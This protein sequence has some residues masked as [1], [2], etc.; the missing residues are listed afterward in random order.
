M[1]TVMCSDVWSTVRTERCSVQH[2]TVAVEM[3]IKTESVLATQREF[4]Y[5]FQKT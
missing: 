4:Q 5:Q 1:L 3:F 2:R